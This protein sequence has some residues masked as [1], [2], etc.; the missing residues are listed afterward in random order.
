[1]LFLLVITLKLLV[2]ASSSGTGKGSSEADPASESCI[3][4]ILFSFVLDSSFKE[5]KNPAQACDNYDSIFT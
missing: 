4:Y 3:V 1:M 5:E 2:S